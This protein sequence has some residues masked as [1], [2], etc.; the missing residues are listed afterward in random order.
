MQTQTI[1]NHY[2]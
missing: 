2:E 1:V